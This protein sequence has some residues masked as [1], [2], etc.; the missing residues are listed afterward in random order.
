MTAATDDEP[1]LLER[2]DPFK[3]PLLGGLLLAM[4]GTWAWRRRR[5]VDESADESLE[6]TFA[7]RSQRRAARTKAGHGDEDH[8][9]SDIL[10]EERRPLEPSAPGLAAATATARAMAASPD[11]GDAVGVAK[12]AGT[13]ES[14]AEAD[15]HM[16]YGLYDQ[17]AELVQA[18]LAREPGRRDLQLKL[19]EVWFVSGNR[20]RFLELARRFHANAATASSPDW[21]K[22]I[23][24]GRQIAPDD[25]LFG[26]GVGGGGGLDLDLEFAS[27]TGHIDPLTP[28]TGQSSP[29]LM[30]GDSARATGNETGLDFVLDEPG[31]GTDLDL[32]NLSPTVEMPRP[33]AATVELPRPTSTTVEMSHPFGPTVELPKPKGE[34][35]DE[36]SIDRLGLDIGSISSIEQLDH[37][38]TEDLTGTDTAGIDS[39]AELESIRTDTRSLDESV[40]DLLSTTAMLK[41]QTGTMAALNAL[42]DLGDEVG[43]IERTGLQ[44]EL[45]TV[46]TPRMRATSDET[47][48]ASEL[49]AYADVSFP[50]SSEEASTLSEVGTKLDL[51]R[52]YID[53]G[54]PEGARS[55]LDEVVEEGNESQQGEARRLIAA[56]P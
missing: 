39:T 47:Q 35:T 41:T 15:F 5:R 8:T 53:M 42:V 13:D 3:W 36:M 11:A 19:L 46:E 29:D 16:A 55:I 1:G 50:L 32:G 6:D 27:T 28:M 21:E 49:T 52:A 56:L 17:A 20:D 4:L 25:S 38:L 31:R 37:D 48:L 40:E 7:E 30:L 10:V 23:I 54:D 24:M 18:S 2:L 45:P 44:T 33:N 34:R 14:L 22:V 26:E 51:A 12:P 43:T 9:K